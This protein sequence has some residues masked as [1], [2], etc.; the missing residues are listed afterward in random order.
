M[1]DKRYSLKR[2]QLEQQINRRVLSGKD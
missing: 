2:R 1:I